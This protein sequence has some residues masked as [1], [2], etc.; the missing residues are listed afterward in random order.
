MT[1][2]EIISWLLKGDVSIQYQTY[3][4]L[5]NVDK[6][7]L[8]KKIETEGWGRKFLSYRQPMAT[9]DNTFTSPSG[10]LRIIL[11]WI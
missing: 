3:R 11:Y 10:R 5:F 6:P 9:G 7:P 2:K 8:R 1:N 4:D